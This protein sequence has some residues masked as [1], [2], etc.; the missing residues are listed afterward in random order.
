MQLWYCATK[1]T[2]SRSRRHQPCGPRWTPLARRRKSC[3]AADASST[4]AS[5]PAL[6][7]ISPLP[8]EKSGIADYSVE[9]I[10]ELEAYYDLTLVVSDA[11]HAG[12]AATA[13]G[14]RLRC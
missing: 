3:A 7:Y 10:A 1:S 11:A 13:L 6:A 9:L 5:R 2:N 8:P 12:V 4:A 14:Q